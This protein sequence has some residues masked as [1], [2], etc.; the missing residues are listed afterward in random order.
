ML[1]FMGR[2]VAPLCVLALAL[3]TG[4]C[5]GGGG[6]GPSPVTTPPTTLAAGPAQYARVMAASPSS[7]S[8]IPS[9]TRPRTQIEYALTGGPYSDLRVYVCLSEDGG[10]NPI[11]DTCV[12]ISAQSLAATVT[13]QPGEATA[14]HTTNAI[15]PLVTQGW[16]SDGNVVVRG[17]SR[18][19]TWMW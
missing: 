13:I 2:L 18:S 11:L 7:G 9:G 5:G 1:R 3:L 15:L 10:A 19:W 17:E 14:G 6:T 8:A 4:A 12:G 16:V